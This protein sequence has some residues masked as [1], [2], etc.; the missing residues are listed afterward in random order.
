MDLSKA[1]DCISHELLVAKLE[2]YGLDELSLKLILDYLCNRKQRTKIGSSFSYWFD[3]SVGVPQ[4]SIFGPLLFI[5]FIDVL[6]FMIIR[7]D[8]CNFTDDNTLYSS[9][10]KI[11]NIFINLKIDLKNVLYWFQVNSLKANPG[12][13]QVMVLEDKKNNILF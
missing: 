1:Y 8:D 9:D 10:K 13:F 7:S 6:F 5:I 4:G 2:C 11:D 12:K 3:I